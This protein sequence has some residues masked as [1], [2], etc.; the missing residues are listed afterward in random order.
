VGSAGI[1]VG[2]EVGMGVGVG[3]DV[4][5]AGSVVGVFV[6]ERAVGVVASDGSQPVAQAMAVIPHTTAVSRFWITCC[7]ISFPLFMSPTSP[8]RTG[9]IGW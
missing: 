7:R 9:V 2:V 4:T 3:L 6:A 8:L 5:R 1:E